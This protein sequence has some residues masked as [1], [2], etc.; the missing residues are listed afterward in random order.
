VI[1]ALGRLRQEDPKFKV[2]LVSIYDLDQ[3]GM[4]TVRRV[5]GC[6]LP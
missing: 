6:I 4:V 2:I 1:P 5:D 3:P